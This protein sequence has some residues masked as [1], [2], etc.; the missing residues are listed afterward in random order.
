[1]MDNGAK[2]G[3]AVHAIESK[4]NI[5]DKTT[6]ANNV[7][8]FAGGGFYLYQSELNCWGNGTLT[9]VSNRAGVKGGGIH[10]I[11]ST[12]KLNLE[13]A[14]VKSSINFIENSAQK[15]GGLCLETESKLYVQ[16]RFLNKQGG[17][18][19]NIHFINNSAMWYGG[20][21]YVADET[22]F[23]VCA[24]K[25]YDSANCFLQILT[26]EIVVTSLTRV[27]FTDNQATIAGSSIFGGLLD[28]C[29]V[30]RYAELRYYG[31]VYRTE[32]IDG[33]IYLTNVSNIKDLK[34]V[35]SY[36]VKVC[37]CKFNESDCSHQPPPIKVMKGEMFTVQVVATDQLNHTTSD[38]II[39]C[40]LK[41]ADSGLDEGQL[42]Q[43]TI[44]DNCTDLEFNVYS[45]HSSEQVQLY[46]AGPCKD[47]NMS[48]TLR[49]IDVQSVSYTHLTLPTIYSV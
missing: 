42:T 18:M 36:P 25:V 24:N 46:A 47:S 37:F 32:D 3:G 19:Y 1:M 40:T 9:I 11:S 23:D 10:A 7:A 45:P 14:F 8:S 41:S 12:I 26:D 30:S 44:G 28:R 27:D 49:V 21:I 34:A 43:Q 15:G 17:T 39:H 2:Y 13:H 5:Y 16:K 33:V 31:P 4:V 29:A 35:S 6:V 22:N 48:L 20:A 38:S